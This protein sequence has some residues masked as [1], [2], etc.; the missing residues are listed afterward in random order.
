M[1]EKKVN[2][3]AH[4]DLLREVG[5]IGAG[6]AVT[7]L[8]KMLNKRIDMQVP[9]INVVEFKNLADF[10]GGPE[11]LVIGVMVDVTGDMNGIMMFL[12]RRESAHTLLDILMGRSE[13]SAEFTEIEVSALCEIGNIL[14]SSYLGS[15]ATMMNKTIIPSIPHLAMD[16]ANA[17]LSVPAIEFGKVSDS[18]L[19]IE[20][21]FGTEDE[22]VSGYFMLVPDLPSFELIFNI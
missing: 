18:V 9:V 7:A 21:V 13:R 2:F 5:N 10:I 3:E 20:S 17:I 22:N 19:F 6:N 8:A 16:M 14:S 4:F 12:V 15:L 1:S 11:A